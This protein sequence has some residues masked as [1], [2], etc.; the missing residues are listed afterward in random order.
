MLLSGAVGIAIAILA[1]KDPL[2]EAWWI[3]V[4]RTG[5]PAA[6][7]EA[8]ERLVEGR[9]FRAIPAIAGLLKDDVEGLG[10]TC[11][12][13]GDQPPWVAAALRR[14]CEPGAAP[15]LIDFAATGRAVEKVWAVQC[16][17]LLGPVWPGIRE[18][19]ANAL[20]D[21]SEAVRARAASALATFGR[22]ACGPLAGALADPEVGVKANALASLICLG[23]EASCAAE[24]IRALLAA[25]PSQS[26]YGDWLALA[27]LAES[28][29]DV[30]PD[31]VGLLDHRESPASAW[32][33][34]RL[35]ELD[36]GVWSA[37]PALE[38][39]V[40]SLCLDDG[41]PHD[42]APEEAA[43]L[44]RRLGSRVFPRL[45]GL[46]QGADEQVVPRRRVLR[47]LFE[48][49]AAPPVE[50]IPPLARILR[51]GDY[52]EQTLAADILG[53]AGPDGSAAAAALRDHLAETDDVVL[54][55]LAAASLLRIDPRDGD[56]TRTIEGMLESEDSMTVLLAVK[57]IAGR[58]GPDVPLVIPALARLARGDSWLWEPSRRVL[59]RLGVKGIAALLDITGDGLPHMEF[60]V[61]ALA[62]APRPESPTVDSAPRQ[63]IRDRLLRDLRDGAGLEDC[64]RVVSPIHEALALLGP[65][66]EAAARWIAGI[67]LDPPLFPL[68]G[69]EACD[70]DLA[71]RARCLDDAKVLAALLDGPEILEPLWRSP[72][73]RLRITAALT[74]RGLGPKAAGTVESLRLLLRDP[75]E[76]V[77][78]SALDAL[79]AIG[80]AARAALP[81]LLDLWRREGDISILRARRQILLARDDRPSHVRLWMEEGSIDRLMPY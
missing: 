55:G 66:A 21:P 51:D 26:P 53:N 36:P 44:L 50:A 77:R 33:L 17:G 46:L 32:A 54:R 1:L 37:H 60:V 42:D 70:W 7:R 59:S 13:F 20:A 31:L 79:A 65:D 5:T 29:A 80:E 45:L 74:A 15:A 11:G 27:A 62:G 41:D 39:E 75:S 10:W 22:G 30:V 76:R 4:V 24:A 81:D 6:A 3:R 8:A 56:A 64:F 73:A 61:E 9:C 19:V 14:L 67:S 57:E 78:L 63:R 47:A 12:Y 71:V 68:D 34:R 72:H 69:G 49:G 28:G 2:R 16:L 40:V 35:A 48:T 58:A 18:S 38:E 43:A 25:A 23:H 52:E